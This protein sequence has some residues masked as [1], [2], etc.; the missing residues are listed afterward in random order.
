MT[1]SVCHNHIAL[2]PSEKYF[3]CFLSSSGTPGYCSSCFRPICL[4]AHTQVFL[5]Q[6]GVQRNCVVFYFLGS[7]RKK[8]HR[9]IPLSR[10]TKYTWAGGCRC[11]F[12]LAIKGGKW[13]RMYVIWPPFRNPSETKNSFPHFLL[14]ITSQPGYSLYSQRDMG[15]PGSYLPGIFPKFL[16]HTWR[17]N[18]KF[19]NL[20]FKKLA[21]PVTKLPWHDGWLLV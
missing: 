15:K 14:T 7:A 6:A 8:R 12:D 3:C 10:F 19:K 4:D 11:P 13:R 1:C 2:W 16:C 5:C 9:I 17:F 20:T 21:F 18:S